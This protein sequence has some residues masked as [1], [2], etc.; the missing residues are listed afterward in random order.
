MKVGFFSFGLMGTSLDKG[1]RE[2]SSIGYEAVEINTWKKA[3]ADKLL[4]RMSKK[5]SNVA[6][7]TWQRGHAYP[8]DLSSEE[9]KRIKDMCDSLH[10]EISALSVH[11]NCFSASDIFSNKEGQRRI[12]DYVGK[13]FE[14]AS[15][16]NV[17]VVTTCSGEVPDDMGK[18]EA[19][20]KLYEMVSLELEYA[21]KYDIKIGWEAH[22]GELVATPDDLLRLMEKINDPLLGINIDCTHF[23]LQGLDP[24]K[25]MDGLLKYTVHTHLKG[26]KGKVA[27]VPGKDEDF[28]TEAWVKKLKDSGYD[29]AISIELMPETDTFPEKA[30]KGFF[31]VN[32]VI[33]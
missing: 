21:R 1:L 23:I 4:E 9:R 10:L 6:L 18:E 8:D 26:V 3:W 25:S 5:R 24:L 32:S 33:H 28:P 27:A 15:D 17:G 19:W 30:K 14:L 2:L 12:L 11:L 7:S 22:S 29:G 16:W 20:D 31:Y 13:C